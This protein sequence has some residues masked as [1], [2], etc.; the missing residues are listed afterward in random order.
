MTKFVDDVEGGRHQEEDWPS[1]NYGMSKLGLIAYTKV[2][3]NG[4]EAVRHL[5]SDSCIDSRDVDKMGLTVLGSARALE[6]RMYPLPW[7]TLWPSGQLE[8]SSLR[9]CIDVPC[10]CADRG[11]EPSACAQPF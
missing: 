1:S 5:P 7:H 10:C 6:S 4:S 11:I 8:A 3:S 9:G 2:S